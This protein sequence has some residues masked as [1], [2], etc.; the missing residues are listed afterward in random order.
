MVNAIRVNG[1]DFFWDGDWVCVIFCRFP[2]AK[3]ASF[4]SAL[5]HG[6]TPVLPLATA[7]GATW[8]DE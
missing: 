1:R 2:K 7:V 6:S 5:S 4:L 8:G 3:S